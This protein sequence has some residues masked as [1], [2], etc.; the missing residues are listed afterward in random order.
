[1]ILWKAF[2]DLP[3]YG[4]N[5]K[6]DLFYFF[7]ILSVL[8]VRSTWHKSRDSA[9]IIKI[10]E[11][12][13]RWLIERRENWEWER[14][15]PLTL[16]NHPRRAVELLESDKLSPPEELASTI[17]GPPYLPTIILFIQARHRINLLTMFVHVALL[18]WNIAM[19]KEQTR[20]LIRISAGFSGRFFSRTLESIFPLGKYGRLVNMIMRK[21]Y[22]YKWLLEMLIEYVVHDTR[23][24]VIK[25]PKFVRT[26][27]YILHLIW[28]AFYLMTRQ[29]KHHFMFFWHPVNNKDK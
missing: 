23:S 3:Q 12:P 16:I 8:V 10:I 20:C 29:H 18:T 6:S 7:P 27:I 13:S 22:C 11:Q 24:D 14:T 5:F 15:L 9:G 28:G 19:R 21:R 25:R 26:K 4:E 17:Y 1:M 2:F